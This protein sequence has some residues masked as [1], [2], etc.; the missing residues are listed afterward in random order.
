LNVGEASGAVRI[1]AVVAMTLA[2]AVGSEIP[3]DAGDL[4]I[5]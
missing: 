2:L 3:I 5:Y 1:A 4:V